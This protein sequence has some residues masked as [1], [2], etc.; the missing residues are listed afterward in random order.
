MKFV[1]M[2]GRLDIP[3]SIVSGIENRYCMRN[4]LGCEK[5]RK[6]ARE[7]NGMKSVSYL[8][9]AFCIRAQESSVPRKVGCVGAL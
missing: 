8:Y 5:G 4:G 1:F 6:G 7:K 3:H 2:E 9:S